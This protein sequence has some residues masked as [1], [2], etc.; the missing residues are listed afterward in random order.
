MISKEITKFSLRDWRVGFA[1]LFVLIASDFL[2]VA[3]DFEYLVF[4]VS[5]DPH[6]TLKRFAFIVGFLNFLLKII[7]FM[8]V[9]KNFAD[10]KHSESQAL[11]RR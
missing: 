5:D 9:V 10:T 7:L 11:L 6:L 4:E 1:S 2:W 3:D 8:C